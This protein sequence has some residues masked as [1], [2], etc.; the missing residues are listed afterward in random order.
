VLNQISYYGTDGL[1]AAVTGDTIDFH[2][3][4]SIW[5]EIRISI[6]SDDPESF[7]ETFTITKVEV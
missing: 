5:S 3:N 6:P 7:G 1:T 4:G 2:A